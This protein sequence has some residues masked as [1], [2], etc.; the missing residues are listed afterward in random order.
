MILAC[1]LTK[2]RYVRRPGLVAAADALGCSISHLRRVVFIKD[3]VSKS[4]TARFRAWKAGQSK[5][6]AKP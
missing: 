6:A 3:R 1:Q 2:R 5:P 4:L